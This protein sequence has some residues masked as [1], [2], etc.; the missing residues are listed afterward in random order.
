MTNDIRTGLN[1]DY[2]VGWLRQ[3]ENQY[4]SA[5]PEV[6]STFS[7]RM[8]RL[9]GYQM[10]AYALGYY[11]DVLNPLDLVRP[12]RERGGGHTFGLN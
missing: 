12:D 11:G 3:E 5:P 4:L 6:A 8:Q 2:V 1:A 7:E 9:A 10:G